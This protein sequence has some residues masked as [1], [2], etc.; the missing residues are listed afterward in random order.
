MDGGRILRSTL[1]GFLGTLRAI[2]IS[3]HVAFFLAVT[4][5]TFGVLL[6][7]INFIILGLLVM[8][9]AKHEYNIIHSKNIN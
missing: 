3:Y 7:Q 4:M 8:Y 5:I 1:S 9:M 6:L 2:T